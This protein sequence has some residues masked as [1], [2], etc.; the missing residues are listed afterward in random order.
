M[1][2]CM[3]NAF[4]L[5]CQIYICFS[6]EH[7]SNSAGPFLGGGVY[8]R[9]GLRFHLAV[10]AGRSRLRPPQAALPGPTRLLK[11]VARLARSSAEGPYVAL[12]VPKELH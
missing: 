2:R 8:G 10:D 4:L 1:W 6:A 3:G 5:A 7:F 12:P 11:N 9:C